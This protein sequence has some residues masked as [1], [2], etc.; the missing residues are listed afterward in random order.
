M[1][2]NLNTSKKW[3]TKSIYVDVSTGEIITKINAMSNYIRLRCTKK[4]YESGS[5]NI[6]EYTHECERSRQIKI[7]I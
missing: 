4:Y 1:S 5:Y 6:R 3:L 2:N 7:K